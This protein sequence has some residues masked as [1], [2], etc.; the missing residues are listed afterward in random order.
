MNN[1]NVGKRAALAM[2]VVVAL[3]MLCT[4][5]AAQELYLKYN[6]HTQVDRA[7][8][9]KGSY[10]NYTN[11]GDG[12]MIIPAGTKINITKKSRRGFFFSHEFS[13]QE[14]FFEYHQGNMGMDM[15]TY[16]DLITST[17]PVNLSKLSA[18]DQKGI[19][20]GR[21]IVGMTREG[22]LA[23][24]GYPATHRTPSLEATRWIY[25][26]NRFRTLAVDFG[27]DGKVS[28]ITN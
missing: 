9:L 5:A 23:A 16:I 18:T 27:G 21:A 28:S 2:F 17:S 22:I 25:W 12:H 15:D 14:A 19:K 4:T 6:V 1:L 10:A 7:N 3:L 11:P 13:G 26:Q 8:V 24:L 20:E